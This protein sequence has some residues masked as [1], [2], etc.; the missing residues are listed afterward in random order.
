MKTYEVSVISRTTGETIY[1]EHSNKA[2]DLK[3]YT[4]QA[5]ENNCYLEVRKPIIAQNR[6]EAI[7]TIIKNGIV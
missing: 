6:K 1:T 2:S 4:E 3:F 7:S 5:I